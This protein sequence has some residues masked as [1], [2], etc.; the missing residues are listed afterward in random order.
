MKWLKKPQTKGTKETRLSI[1]M[2]IWE[3]IESIS[4]REGME[5]NEVV[6]QAL[7]YALRSEIRALMPKKG[8]KKKTESGE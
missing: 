6:R 8:R 3:A 5:I 2:E 1:P 7:A 4:T